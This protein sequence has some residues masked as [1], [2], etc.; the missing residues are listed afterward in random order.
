MRQDVGVS[1]NGD[2]GRDGPQRGER[3]G[4]EGSGRSNSGKRPDSGSS[5]APRQSGGSSWSGRSS[6]GGAGGSSGRGRDER[7]ASGA[8]RGASSRDSRPSYGNGGGARGRDDRPAGNSGGGWSRGSGSGA[9]SGSSWRAPASGSVAT[10]MVALRHRVHPAMGMVA[11]PRRVHLDMAVAEPRHLARLAMEPA[12]PTVAPR[13]VPTNVGR[14]AGDLT[15]VRVH[16]AQTTG[17]RPGATA[18]VATPRPLVVPMGVRRRGRT[19][20]AVPV[21]R[22]TEGRVEANAL[23]PGHRSRGAV[24]T[25][26]A[27]GHPTH[28]AAATATPAGPAIVDVPAVTA[29]QPVIV[30]VPGPLVVDPT[31]A[32]QVRTRTVPAPGR[33]RLVLTSSV[34]G[35]ALIVLRRPGATGTRPVA[36]VTTRRETRGRLVRAAGRRRATAAGHPPWVRWQPATG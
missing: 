18:V 34:R 1:S 31:L 3:R 8:G 17:R 30:P 21:H 7:P 32:G 36:V 29:V 20:E 9:P 4:S 13:A 35:P 25:V 28:V 26:P 14:A 33:D 15:I 12:A 6:A 23:A 16:A 24:V 5:G 27:P 11:L 10:G 2:D 22:A 19:T